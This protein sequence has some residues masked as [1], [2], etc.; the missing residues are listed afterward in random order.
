M[1]PVGQ[2]QRERYVSSSLS[3]DGTAGEVAVYSCRLVT[4]CF[5]VRFRYNFVIRG[6]DS[7]KNL[8]TNLGKT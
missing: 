8:T 5:I 7:Q 6:P 4:T 2:N 3:G 1:E